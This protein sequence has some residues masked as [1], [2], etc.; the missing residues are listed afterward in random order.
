MVII[1]IMVIKKAKHAAYSIYDI[2]LASPDKEYVT[3]NTIY[4]LVHSS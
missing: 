1:M 4:G 2:W 3:N